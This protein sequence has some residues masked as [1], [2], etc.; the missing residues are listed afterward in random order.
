MP[1]A[2]AG[3]EAVITGQIAGA[4]EN[5]AALGQFVDMRLTTDPGVAAAGL[6]VTEGLLCP[7][8]TGAARS[9][10]AADIPAV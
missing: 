5:V 10:M 6:T 9:S 2:M 1:P 8:A 4:T 7:W 3:A